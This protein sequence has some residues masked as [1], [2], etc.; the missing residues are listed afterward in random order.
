MLRSTS[1]PFSC[2]E[3]KVV[4]GEWGVVNGK[5]TES[6]ENMKEKEASPGEELYTVCPISPKPAWE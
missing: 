3:E 5:A 6:T 2:V 4:S 1:L